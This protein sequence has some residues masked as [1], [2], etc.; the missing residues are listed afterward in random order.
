[1]DLRDQLAEFRQPFDAITA[2]ATHAAS[3]GFADLLWEPLDE[4]E[5]LPRIMETRDPGVI[6]ETPTRVVV[7]EEWS[8]ELRYYAGGWRSDQHRIHLEWDRIEAEGSEMGVLPSPEAAARFA[9][10]YLARDEALQDIDVPRRIRHERRETDTVRLAE[11]RA[12]AAAAME[13]G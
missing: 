5:A 10:R 12:T 1:M 13:E 2:V 11:L 3:V 8:G 9:E 7:V 4:N 6:F